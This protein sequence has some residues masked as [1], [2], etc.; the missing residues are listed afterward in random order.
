MH[1]NGRAG[2]DGRKSLFLKGSD[3]TLAQGVHVLEVSG[4][5]GEED[6][7]LVRVKAK[8]LAGSVAIEDFLIPHEGH[9]GNSDLAGC[10][11]V[12]DGGPWSRVQLSG[13]KDHVKESF[14]HWADP[15]GFL[16][17]TPL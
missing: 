16:E 10:A 12:E 9:R 14:V 6:M 2:P 5:K 15:G 13:L 3:K 7:V 1:G 17:K 4:A 11:V 8:G